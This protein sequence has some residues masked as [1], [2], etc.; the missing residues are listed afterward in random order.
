MRPVSNSGFIVWGETLPSCFRCYFC[1]I[2]RPALNSEALSSLFPQKR[3]G[4]TTNL[5]N[6]HS[7]RPP[8]V[9]IYRN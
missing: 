1:G 9:P 8:Y 7:F 5:G 6:F 3:R 4:A 2:P